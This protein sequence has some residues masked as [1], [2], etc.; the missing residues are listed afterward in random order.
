MGTDFSD[1]NINVSGEVTKDDILRLLSDGLI[2]NAA[3]ARQF[4]DTILVDLQRV[5]KGMR[6]VAGDV[7]LDTDK[8]GQ[9]ATEAA[10][11]NIKT[12]DF[13]SST[14]TP[15]IK[16]ASKKKSLPI[17]DASK[18]EAKLLESDPKNFT[19]KK[20]LQDLADKIQK[21]YIKP[22]TPLSILQMMGI[23][24]TKIDKIQKN[25][26]DVLDS[27]SKI[28]GGPLPIKKAQSKNDEGPRTK[29]N[30]PKAQPTK[31]KFE[32][33]IAKKNEVVISGFSDAAMASLAKS[34]IFKHAKMPAIDVSKLFKRQSSIEE[35]ILGL[36]VK[37]SKFV[38]AAYVGS[39]GLMISSLFDNGPFKGTKML[40]GKVVEMATK[41]LMKS[42]GQFWLKQVGRLG[43][44]VMS[45]FLGI[46]GRTA[47]KAVLGLGKSVS[48]VFSTFAFKMATRLSKVLKWVP[49]IGSLFS[50]AGAYT[51]FKANDFTGGVM[52]L[53]SGIA[54]LPGMGPAG[55]AISIGM[56]VLSAIRDF[57]P[58]EKRDNGK[59]FG[60][61]ALK[62]M[63]LLQTKLLA[64]FIPKAAWK[65]LPVLG[66]IIS[67]GAAATRFQQG[68]TTGGLLDLSSAIAAF[69]PGAGMAVSIGLDVLSGI[70]DSKS[71]AE[72]RKQA[73][74]STGNAV[75]KTILSL[76]RGFFTK[77]LKIGILKKIPFIGSAFNFYDAWN[78]FKSGNILKGIISVASGIAGFVPG[79]GTAI[80]I[81]LDILNAFISP[82]KSDA[83]PLPPKTPS[84]SIWTKLKTFYK[85]KIEKFFKTSTIGRAFSK[86]Q[87]GWA[88][89]TNGQYGKGMLDISKGIALFTPMGMMFDMV[90]RLF[91]A[92]KSASPT[93][94]S[95]A[96]RVAKPRPAKIP[97]THN[98]ELD[99]KLEK[100]SGNIRTRAVQANRPSAIAPPVTRA[101]PTVQ[102]TKQFKAAPTQVKPPSVV[103]STKPIKPANPVTPRLVETSFGVLH[104]DLVVLTSEIK[105]MA[106][107]MGKMGQANVTSI[108]KTSAGSDSGDVRDPAYSLRSRAWGYINE[109]PRMI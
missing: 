85:E 26:I 109:S 23:E 20:R 29:G 89:I 96:G 7:V 36:T 74:S 59:G 51:R 75:F 66:S 54:M 103:I 53:V 48:S 63:V 61:A 94:T 33:Y 24:K 95:G 18:A 41:P 76:T 12:A 25:W 9:A 42:L 98:K 27:P 93:S 47:T 19:L 104:K 28:I 43:H 108:S 14:P 87:S 100:Q 32:S 77:F 17:A 68:D 65:R 52:D 84:V 106:A 3:F 38:A 31:N 21:E 80:S 101:T 81:G 105:A 1:F 69:I 6:I 83:T 56:D 46:F 4:A 5:I 73:G 34:P 86:L 99:S 35:K 10:I 102:T 97:T 55:M 60:V 15:K 71:T 70:R 107:G 67:I 90:S 16:P 37:Y 79:A 39:I 8:I 64:K 22:R 44:E 30:A 92:D 45:T 49:G 57:Q 88:S 40:I 78:Q 11:K 58:K 62:S 13:E 72:E 50:F 91:E 82:K 2:N